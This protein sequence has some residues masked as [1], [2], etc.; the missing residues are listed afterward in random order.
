MCA[1]KCFAV[2]FSEINKTMRHRKKISDG[3]FLEPFCF[4]SK[5]YDAL[6]NDKEAKEI[7]KAMSLLM[8]VV[9]SCDDAVS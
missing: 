6:A 4:P 3:V 1:H 7:R 9:F 5:V 2:C 8:H